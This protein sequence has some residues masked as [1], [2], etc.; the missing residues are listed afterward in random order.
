MTFRCHQ[1]FIAITSCIGAKT[2]CSLL[3]PF[4]KVFLFVTIIICV[5]VF[6]II[7]LG[8]LKKRVYSLLQ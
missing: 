5:A 3:V 6:C 7:Y 4:F 2:S 1:S 8:H